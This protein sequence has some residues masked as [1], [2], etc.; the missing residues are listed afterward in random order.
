MKC[1]K[2]AIS[3]RYKERLGILQNEFSAGFSDLYSIY[4]QVMSA[5][6]IFLIA[7]D[8]II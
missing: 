2:N 8:F 4:Q 7:T 3:H 5:P 6:T 1:Y